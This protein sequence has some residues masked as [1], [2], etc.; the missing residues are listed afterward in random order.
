[1]KESSPPPEV[2]AYF[3]KIGKKYGAQGGKKAAA[4]MSAEARSERGKKASDAALASMTK[5]QRSERAKV[6]AAARWRKK[7]N[8]AGEEGTK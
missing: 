1:M 5:K 4:N 3:R 2:T 8:K 7:E 6:A